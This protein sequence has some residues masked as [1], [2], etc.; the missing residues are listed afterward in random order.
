MQSK[1]S[2]RRHLLFEDSARHCHDE[3]ETRLLVQTKDTLVD[4]GLIADAVVLQFK[5]KVLG[6]KDF[7]QCQGIFLAPL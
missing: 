3:R 7:R 6:A 4:D 1:T 5:I 2:A